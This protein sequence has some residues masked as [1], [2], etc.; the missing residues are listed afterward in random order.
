M[1]DKRYSA[2]RA[3]SSSISSIVYSWDPSAFFL[4]NESIRM[5][6]EM[7]EMIRITRMLYFSVMTHVCFSIMLLLSMCGTSSAGSV[8]TATMRIL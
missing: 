2:E 4:L 3:F 7:I 8:S 1:Y 5:T 6:N